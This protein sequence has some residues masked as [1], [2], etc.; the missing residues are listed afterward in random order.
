MNTAVIQSEESASPGGESSH[1]KFFGNAV[2][3]ACG[4]AA[5]AIVVGFFQ[6]P[7]P[8]SGVS[9]APIEL[10]LGI[11]GALP[12]FLVI[13]SSGHFNDAVIEHVVPSLA[14]LSFGQLACLALAMAVGQELLFRGL[15]PVVLRELDPM[16]AL[17]I[18]NCL[19]GLCY[20][21]NKGGFVTML[22]FGCY[23]SALMTSGDTTN[24][25][26]PIIAHCVF[27]LVMLPTLANFGRK[28][29]ESPSENGV[30]QSKSAGPAT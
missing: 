12:L 18:A 5:F 20:A 3:L 30:H 2:T 29:N 17:V 27:L 10:M 13:Y 22:L 23:L 9:V 8:W 26:R 21:V 28:T 25:V 1:S 15:I 19:F 7:Q 4:F 16:W 14:K 11:L 6:S 24:L